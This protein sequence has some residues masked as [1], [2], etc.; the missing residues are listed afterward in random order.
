MVVVSRDGTLDLSSLDPGL[1]CRLKFISN[2][3]FNKHFA[4]WQINDTSDLN[5]YV[6]ILTVAQHLHLLPSNSIII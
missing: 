5:K 1:F 4:H 6:Y 3:N 2:G